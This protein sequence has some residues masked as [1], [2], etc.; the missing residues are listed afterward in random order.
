[1]TCKVQDDLTVTDDVAIG[2]LATVGGTLGVTG[3]VTANAGVV[4]DNFTL[5]GTT[6]ALS[7]GDFTVDV[8]GDI[9]L[10]ADGGDIRFKDGGVA[11]AV[12]GNSSSDFF[13]GTSV[14]DK[15]ILFKGNDGGSTIT[16]LSLD[17]SDAGAAIFS[18]T[19]MM[20]DRLKHTGDTDTYFQ[21]SAA[22]TIELVAGNVATF[23]TTGSEVTINENSA[24]VDFRVESDGNANMLFVDAGNNRVG[25]GTS[26][27]VA[28]FVVSNGGAAGIEFQPEIDT[29]TN[30]ITNFDRAASAYMNLRLDA[31]QIDIQP[32][33]SRRFSV[34]TS[35]TV[36]NEDGADHDFRVETDAQGFAFFIDAASDTVTFS[37]QVITMTHSG[38]GKQLELVSTDTDANS[39]PQLDLYRNSGSPADGDDLGRIFFYGENDADEKI[40]MVLLRTAVND[41]SDGS[42]D[43]QFQIYTYVAGAQADRLHINPA[44]TIFN[45]SSK[46]SDFRV[47]SDA[48][49]QCFFVD[50]N[51]NVSITNAAGYI[52]KFESNGD[53]QRI[54]ST[55][56][57]HTMGMCAGTS[58]ATSSN[59]SFIKLTGNGGAIRL[60]A[61]N[62]GVNLNNDATS[63]SS[64]SDSRLKNVT[65]T[66]TNA[67]ED[68][69]T[70]EPVKFTWKHDTANKLNVG[71]IAQSVQSV[72]PEAVDSNDV[73]DDGTEYLSVRY[74]E[75]IPLL[76]AALQQAITKIE[77]LET[78]ITALES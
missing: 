18:G 1:M 35:Q 32:S 77:T 41:V 29:D 69:K 71:L 44:E 46:D 37:N 43:S 31:L 17:M 63:F 24:D 53:G 21:F 78:R 75:V 11:I 67:I 74:T 3:V 30:R 28:D 20:P 13:I 66:F 36:V 62:L 60:T 68:I 45:E 50:G 40:E 26:A 42:E 27:P 4:V 16:A 73:L 6:L 56:V 22:N 61:N 7:S 2:G 5:D 51:S 12:L 33:G 25:V 64:A 59:N 76:T 55:N 54:V 47:E 39:G 9:I 72:L 15:D 58:Y 8:A 23:K 34:A 70:L 57:A 52:A 19:L 38:N 65:G 14:Q 49:S 10:D 48:Q